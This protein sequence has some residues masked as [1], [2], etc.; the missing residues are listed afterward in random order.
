MTITLYLYA[1]THARDVTGE[2]VARHLSEVDK[3]DESAF[4]GGER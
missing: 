3:G 2:V 4:V 1:T